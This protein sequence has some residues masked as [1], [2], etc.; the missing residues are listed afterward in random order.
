MKQENIEFKLSYGGFNIGDKVYY[1]IA[2]N[3]YGLGTVVA[4]KI[5]QK[6]RLSLPFLPF[7][8]KTATMVIKVG[9]HYFEKP[10]HKCYKVIDGGSSDA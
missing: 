7:T 1:P 2:I 4:G 8:H 10:A 9:S 3:E 5:E 6:R